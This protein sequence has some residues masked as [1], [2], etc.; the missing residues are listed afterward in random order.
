[1]I[2]FACQFCQGPLKADGI[3]SY[4]QRCHSCQVQYHESGKIIAYLLDDPDNIILELWPPPF[5]DTYIVVPKE[6]KASRIEIVCDLPHPTLDNALQFA[7][8]LYSMRAF[9]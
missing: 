1:M 8:K 5:W 4:I 2:D 6:G 9:Q 7:R 3:S